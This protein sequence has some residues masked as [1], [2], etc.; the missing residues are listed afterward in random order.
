MY[1]VIYGQPL[2]NIVESCPSHRA[3]PSDLGAF[4]HPA[5]KL[6]R[7]PKIQPAW[8]ENLTAVTTC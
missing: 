4:L 1:Y 8:S 2:K 7:L 3:K 5:R 6:V